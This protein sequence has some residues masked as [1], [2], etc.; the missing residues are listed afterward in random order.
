MILISSAKDFPQFLLPAFIIVLRKWHHRI[1]YFAQRQT[2]KIILKI[3]VSLL[4]LF[5][6]I[7][8]VYGGWNLM[9]H[10]D[11]SSLQMSVAYLEHSP[12][13]DYFIPGIILFIANGLCSF[14]VLATILFN[15]KD[16][17]WFII[18]QG[19]LFLPGGS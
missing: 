6:G 15:L 8:A 16:Y 2:L 4:L 3:F 14:I 7:G 18:A 13:N 9:T 11:G 10:P 12:F 5:N 1:K 19:E 17:P